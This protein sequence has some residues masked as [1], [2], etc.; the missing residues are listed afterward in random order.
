MLLY[1]VGLL[2][3]VF[4]F[5]VFTLGCYH[6]NLFY[7][8]ISILFFNA[9]DSCQ[10]LRWYGC[11]TILNM[12]YFKH[13]FGSLWLWCSTYFLVIKF[14]LL[15]FVYTFWKFINSSLPCVLMDHQFNSLFD[16]IVYTFL[17]SII[18]FHFYGRHVFVGS[19][20]TLF[21][22]WLYFSLLFSLIN[23]ITLHHLTLNIVYLN[24][25][26]CLQQIH[27]IQSYLSNLF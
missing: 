18:R 17:L 25:V 3:H 26:L 15:N 27:V 10:Q 9:C 13:F 16:F 5:V 8:F 14:C 19:S 23:F 12:H 24:S 7:Y 22:T 21:I 4:Q 20:V 1:R 11:T 6:V 2:D